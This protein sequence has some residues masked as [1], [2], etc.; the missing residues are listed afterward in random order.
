MHTKNSLPIPQVGGEITQIS[1]DGSLR[2]GIGSSVAGNA[3]D[4]LVRGASKLDV[5][6]PAELPGLEDTRY[7]N[8]ESRRNDPSDASR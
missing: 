3:P 6:H 1:R 2:C 5:N 8:G 7:S 4:C